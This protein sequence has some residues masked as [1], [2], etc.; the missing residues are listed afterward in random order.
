[1]SN[2]KYTTLASYERLSIARDA[3][4]GRETDHFRLSVTDPVGA[5][6]AGQLATIEEQITR[7]QQTVRELEEEQAAEQSE[8]AAP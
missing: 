8:L 5:A 6:N 3:L 1:M 4:K 2:I 7:L